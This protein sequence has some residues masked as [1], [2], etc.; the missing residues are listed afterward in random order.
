MLHIETKCPCTSPGSSNYFL[1]QIGY[2]RPTLSRRKYKTLQKENKFSKYYI[3]FCIPI[4]V[5]D[6]INYYFLGSW[7]IIWHFYKNTIYRVI[8]IYHVSCQVSN[9]HWFILQ[10]LDKLYTIILILQMRELRF[11]Q[12]FTPIK[13]MSREWFS[14]H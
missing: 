6:L 2:I 4:V 1:Y 8:T 14:R 7:L 9:V 11:A 12:G 3:E 5:A 13:E 10:Q